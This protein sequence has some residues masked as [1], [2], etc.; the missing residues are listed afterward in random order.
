MSNPVEALVV[1]GSALVALA[2][3]IHGPEV[4]WIA[5]SLTP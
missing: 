2:P 3:A 1:S 4:I 5:V